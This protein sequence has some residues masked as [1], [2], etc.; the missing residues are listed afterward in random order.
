MAYQ[1]AMEM[2]AHDFF[3]GYLS[4]E[5]MKGDPDTVLPE[6]AAKLKEYIAAVTAPDEA[7]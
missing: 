5:V 1:R 6:Y 2:L 4:V 7:E 3:E